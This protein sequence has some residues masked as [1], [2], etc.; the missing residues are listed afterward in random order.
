MMLGCCMR[1][2]I[3]R[4]ILLLLLP[5]LASTTNFLGLLNAIV[6]F[7]DRGEN[8]TYGSCNGCFCITE[9]EDEMCPVDR[10]PQ[11]EFGSFIPVLRSLTWKNP[12]QLECDP[13]TEEECNTTPPLEVGGAC[14]VTV[15]GKSSGTCTTN[16]NYTVSTYSGSFEEAKANSSLYVTHAGACGTCSSLQDLSVYMEF[17]AGLSDYAGDCGIRG[18]VDAADGVQCFQEMGFTYA[19]SLTWYYNTKLVAAECLQY[20]AIYQVLGRP[21][22]GPP[23]QCPLAR[24]LECDEKTAG[25]IFEQYAGRTRRNSGLLSNIARPCSSIIDLEHSDPCT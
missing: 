21:P 25:P 2:Q 23:P 9:G 7:L 20:C 19:C 12:Y 5:S 4:I 1:P 3:Y 14:I 13:F 6:N 17:G 18:R 22:N 15:E 11:T 24:C 8:Q 10:M 16:S